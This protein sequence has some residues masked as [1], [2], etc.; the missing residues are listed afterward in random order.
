VDEAGSVIAGHGRLLAA[1]E[2]GL[3]EVPVI[4]L[5]GLTEAQKRAYLLADNKLALNAGWDDSL[6][7]CGLEE[8][9]ALGADLALTGFSPEELN[10]I[11]NGWQS[12]IVPAEKDGENLTGIDAMLKVVVATEAKEL[13]K[14]TITN[15]LD[16]AGVSYELR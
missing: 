2:L 12:D 6:L 8:L 14:Q 13:A 10:V 1:A 16:S 11:F 5:A 3:D 4:V 9:T 15:A 7:K